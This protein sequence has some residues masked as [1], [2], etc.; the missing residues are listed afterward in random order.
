MSKKKITKK[1]LSYTVIYEPVKQGGYQ[2]SVP[3]LEGLIT[4]GRNFDEARKMAKDAIHCYCVLD[5]IH[6]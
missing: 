3:R 2:V 1:E 4:F 5:E 6:R